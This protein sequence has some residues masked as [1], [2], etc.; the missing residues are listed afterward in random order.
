MFPERV[1]VRPAPG[2]RRCLGRLLLAMACL[3]PAALYAAH[4]QKRA[5]TLGDFVSE[6]KKTRPLSVLMAE[7]VAAL[8]SWARP[9]T[10]PAA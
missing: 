9:R 10:V 1:R 7:R 5:A 2:L 3:P 6:F 8:R 4:A